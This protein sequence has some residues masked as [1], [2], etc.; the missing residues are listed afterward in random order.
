MAGFSSYYG[1]FYELSRV[2]SQSAFAKDLHSFLKLDEPLQ[3]KIVFAA[4]DFITAGS[5]DWREVIDRLAADTGDTASDLSLRGTVA[6][7]IL[8]AVLDDGSAQQV[9]DLIR[10]SVADSDVA[11]LIEQENAHLVELFTPSNDSVFK[12][13]AVKVSTSYLPSLAETDA[14]WEL[15]PVSDSSGENIGFVPIL[16]FRIATDADSRDAETFF[17]MTPNEFNQLKDLLDGL[18]ASLKHVQECASKLAPSAN[19]CRD[20]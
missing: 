9:L 5:S 3:R 1:S 7:V 10:R 12:Y 20:E 8:R 6:G 14:S 19:G 13:H 16:V 4:A 15:R 2:V 18:G 17:Q 11:A